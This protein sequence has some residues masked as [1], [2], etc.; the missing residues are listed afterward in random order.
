MFDVLVATYSKIILDPP[1]HVLGSPCQ[2]FGTTLPEIIL[3]EPSKGLI[4]ILL[5]LLNSVLVALSTGFWVGSVSLPVSLC[6]A[7]LISFV[8]LNF[9]RIDDYQ[10]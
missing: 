1:C 6:T 7:M 3:V 4:C 10:T 9:V 8:N 2:V 5:H